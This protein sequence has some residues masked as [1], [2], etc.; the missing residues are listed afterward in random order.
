MARISLNARLVWAALFLSV[1]LLADGLASDPAFAVICQ[2]AGAGANSGTDGGQGGNTACGADADASGTGS[3]NTAIGDFADGS[4]TGSSNTAIG[5]NTDSSG[6]DSLNVA[7]GFGAN[8]SG[9]SSENIAT[10]ANANA[11]GDD[12]SN[13]AGGVFANASGDNSRNIASGR[14]A[15]AS[16]DGSSNVAIGKGAQAIG[17]GTSNT[18]VGANAHANFA[19]SS[20]FGAG[21]TATRENQ[22]AFGTATN[23]YTMAGLAS[24][25]SKAAQGTPTHLV[26]SNAQGDLAAYTFAE[27]GLATS[28]DLAETNRR[29]QTNTQGV[30]IALSLAG[31]PMLLPSEAIAVAAG[32]GTFEGESA[33]GASGAV[34]VDRNVQLNGGI[35]FAGNSVGGR[36]GVRVGW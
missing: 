9:N 18:A 35:G 31:T 23:T 6:D 5:D 28:S 19:N 32:W 33:F 36:A 13:I 7:T 8:S 10:G 14:D 29:V 11:S 3:S 17:S 12:G 34:R 20:A 16:G 25:A 1:L 2:N 15:N 22:Q 26:T 24:V 30:A 21:A 27:L 4:G